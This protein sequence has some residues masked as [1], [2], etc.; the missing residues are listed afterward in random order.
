MRSNLGLAGRITAHGRTA[1]TLPENAGPL[2]W[3]LQVPLPVCARLGIIG[4]RAAVGHRWRLLLRLQ[5]FLHAV[6]AKPQG[7]ES[8]VLGFRQAEAALP[9]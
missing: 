7:C 9:R 8:P 3:L 2:K 4:G 5:P 6:D 1:Y